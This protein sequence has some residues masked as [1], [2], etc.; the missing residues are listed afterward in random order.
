MRRLAC[1]AA[2]ALLFVLPSAVLAAG[3]APAPQRQLELRLAPGQAA[4][5]VRA[6]VEPGD[7]RAARREADADGNGELDKQERAVAAGA[8][9]RKAWAGLSLLV[10]GEAVPLTLGETW[11]SADLGEVVFTLTAALPA[12]D[13]AG[14]PLELRDAAATKAGS[15]LT[16][17][18]DGLA[19]KGGVDLLRRDVPWISVAT[20]VAPKAP[21]TPAQAWFDAGRAAIDERA[22]EAS[23]PDRAKNVILFLG[24]GMSLSTVVA[25]RILDGQQ[26]GMRGEEN[27]LS[28]E[29]FPHVALSK[30]YS[31]N[32]QVPDSAPTMTAIVTGTKTA[33]AM[34]SV[35]E[36]TPRGGFA[37]APAHA[38]RTILELAEDAGLQTGL[39]T[40]TRITHAT[41]AACYAH[42]PE[43]EW[44]SDGQLPEAAR[45]AGYPD[46]ARQLVE[47][48]HG[49]GPDV[50]LGGGRA[51]FFGKDVADP[52]YPDKK[53]RRLD[54]R[55]LVAAWRDRRGSAAAWCWNAQQLRALDPATCGPVL[56]LFE[57]SHMRYETDRA[58]D[59]GGEP[60][61]SEMTAFA[62]ERLKRSPKGYFLMVEGGRIDHGHHEGNAYR[63]LT[64]TVEMAKAVDAV[65]Q[66]VNLEDTLVLVTADHGHVMTIGGWATRGNPIL[67]LVTGND[68]KGTPRAPGPETWDRDL[69]G[70]PYT[71][72]SYANGPGNAGASD[73]QPDGAKKL[74]HQP[75]H[76]AP[77]VKG[78]ADLSGVD[79][80]A[81]DFLQESLVPLSIETHS[82]EDVPVYA[83]GAGSR[84]V[85]GVL[86]QNALYF[87]MV[88]ALGLTAPAP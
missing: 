23:R 70:L 52:E 58:A 13:E 68:E 72:L 83:A 32:Q 37:E 45:A 12:P 34:L 56:G 74:P 2:A 78:R 47:S 80:T 39:V 55:D 67:G 69:L 43:R 26:H 8:L 51:N 60:S 53:G 86:E 31:A 16:V 38:L 62:V 28:F 5:V 20:L 71:T 66:R 44:E 64:E 24:D 75:R 41:P 11:A 49:D 87:V 88:R 25:A 29:R 40:T 35:D 42:V 22:R 63:A 27:R 4:L 10:R 76:V 14:L 18:A 81:A 77:A 15:P 79:T 57:P 61:L 19:L 7:A 54:G 6:G 85:G 48:A 3:K 36:T 17:A 21:A 30:T 33:D 82:G 46:I 50:I 65:L 84:L 59:A 1:A 9:S 73:Q